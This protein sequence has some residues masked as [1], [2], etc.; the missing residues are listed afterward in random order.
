MFD[1]RNKKSLFII[2]YFSFLIK[3]SS[4]RNQGLLIFLEK[5]TVLFDTVRPKPLR[6]GDAYLSPTRQT[7]PCFSIEKPEGQ[8]CFFCAKMLS[9]LYCLIQQENITFLFLLSIELSN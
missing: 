2:P 3:K 7:T 1:I 8:K 4:K 9:L 6:F 5:A